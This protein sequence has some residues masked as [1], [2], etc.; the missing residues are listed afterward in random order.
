MIFF[1]LYRFTAVS[2]VAE[3]FEHLGFDIP[4]V[5]FIIFWP[6]KLSASQITGAV[7]RG[8]VLLGPFLW[9]SVPEHTVP[10]EERLSV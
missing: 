8:I 10:W 1:F 9:C 3:P 4:Y 7:G 6:T 5:F 2:D